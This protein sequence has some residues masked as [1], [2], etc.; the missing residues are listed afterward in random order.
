LSLAA[1]GAFV[2]LGLVPNRS[3]PVLQ[4]KV[5]LHGEKATLPS[6]LLVVVAEVG[7]EGRRNRAREEEVAQ[8]QQRDMAAAG[9][10]GG[11]G[12]G[13]SVDHSVAAGV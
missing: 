10:S 8:G 6:L 9:G 11:G 7:T 4:L 1:T 12:P 2:L 5:P 3:F 13:G